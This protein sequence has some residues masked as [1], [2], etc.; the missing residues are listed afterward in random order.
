MKYLNAENINSFPSSKRASVN[1]LMTEN[2]VTR[3]INR[4][5]D[6]DSFVITNGLHT[7]ND[8][9]T[10]IPVSVWDQDFADL[11]FVI[12]GY[13]FSISHKDYNSGMSFLLTYMQFEPSDMAEHTLY[14]GIFI[15]KSD[16][17]FP[18]LW[19]Q[20][21]SP[22]NEYKAIVFYIDGDVPEEP[23]GYNTGN[24]DFYS[25]PLVKYKQQEDGK[26]GMVVPIT[27]LFKFS[28]KSISNI[29]GGEINII[30]N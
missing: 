30:P 5:I 15:D 28:S 10:D 14:A 19:G 13:Y 1:K 11:E 24:L 23:N 21:N 25:L 17:N 12:R 26:W 3:L 29:D 4:L 6:M 27:S 18:E 2:S 20:E 8:F 16:K 22:D 9:L 7:N